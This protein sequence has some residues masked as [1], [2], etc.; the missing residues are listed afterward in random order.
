MSLLNSV[1]LKL[2][3]LCRSRP[4]TSPHI[5][6]YLGFS[7][8]LRKQDFLDCLREDRVPLRGSGTGPLDLTTAVSL[9]TAT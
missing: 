1:Q 3:A 6:I 2:Q 9:K 5:K 8:F 7:Y 4:M